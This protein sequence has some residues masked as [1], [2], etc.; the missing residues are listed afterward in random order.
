LAGYSAKAVK[1]YV[2]RRTRTAWS[3]PKFP[4]DD[5]AQHRE[6]LRQKSGINPLYPETLK[7]FSAAFVF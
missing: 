2:F 6:T 4:G 3:D 5:S 1:N 7:N